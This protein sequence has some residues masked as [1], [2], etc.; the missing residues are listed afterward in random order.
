M[1]EVRLVEEVLRYRGG[2]MMDGDSAPVK[3][4]PAQ[5]E[6]SMMGDLESVRFLEKLP[7]GSAEQQE[8]E[9]EERRENQQAEEERTHCSF[10]PPSGDPRGAG[11]EENTSRYEQVE[12]VKK[13]ERE[14]VH[15]EDEEVKE[16]DNIEEQ[17]GMIRKESL[18]SSPASP[19]GEAGFHDDDKT[20]EE[21]L[22]GEVMVSAEEIQEDSAELPD[23]K[24]RTSFYGE[25][26]TEEN[27]PA[28][29]SKENQEESTEFFNHKP[30]TA[31]DPE[32]LP[33]NNLIASTED[34]PAPPAPAS[35]ADLQLPA[36]KTNAP[37]P[38]AALP[39]KT[40]APPAGA[41]QRRNTNSSSS[42]LR[43]SGAPPPLN[44]GNAAVKETAD[45]VVK[46][47]RTAGGRRAAKMI[48]AKST[49]SMDG[50][51]SPGSRSPSSRSSTPNR[52]V[53]KVA[54]VRTPPR[55]PGSARG[56]TPPPTSHPMPDLSSVKS[57]VGSTENLKHA[58]GGGKVHIVNKKLDL[59]NVTSKCGS[60]GNLHHKP[61]GGKV[62]IKSDKV[63]FK[64][65]QSKVGSLEK[66][67]HVPGG[68]K[69]KIESHKLMFRENAKARTDH[70]A[71]IVLQD[72]SSPRRL[73]N[74]SSH[75][76]LN[77]SEATPLDNLADQVSAS[78]AKQ[79]L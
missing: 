34:H 1:E 14:I 64:A 49:E 4:G 31:F 59:S 72:N 28:Y 27:Q 13:E 35:S 29:P 2:A 25:P 62:E 24:T 73:S 33:E 45:E 38:P 71:E 76:S 44:K 12:E 61:G 54:V 74:T 57:K 32:H 51:N 43:R 18:W 46:A 67:T 47:S 39:S 75:G 69:K 22:E 68:G 55:S 66:V 8:K 16:E 65:V 5:E 26:P 11:L 37:P 53:K 6:Q 23:H 20:K 79:G 30:S 10:V 63:D 50:V 48:S 17:G 56:W 40:R 41:A 3:D 7:N 60:K 70:G 42:P 78:L 52:D 19:P 77:A 21:Q 36:N 9:G 15:T 58:P